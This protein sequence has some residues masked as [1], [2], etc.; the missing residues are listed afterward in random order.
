MVSYDAT[1]S[2][3]KKFY[4]LILLALVLRILFLPIESLCIQSIQ[5]GGRHNPALFRLLLRLSQTVP[6]VALASGA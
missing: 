3:V 4:K 2:N 1:C 5:S 6:D